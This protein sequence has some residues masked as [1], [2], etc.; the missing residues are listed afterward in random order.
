MVRG[1]PAAR[2]AGSRQW[3]RF[4][5]VDHLPAGGVCPVQ[6]L[7]G[8]AD[9]VH[10]EAHDDGQV[11]SD[12]R[13]LSE[14]P[15]APTKSNVDELARARMH[16]VII[17]TLT[18]SVSS[19]STTLITSFFEKHYALE[20]YQA[21]MHSL[22]AV[23]L[24]VF[25]T[26]LA[27][28][29]R[30]ATPHARLAAGLTLA[31][32][33]GMATIMLVTMALVSGSIS[34]TGGVDGITQGWLYAIGWW[35]HFK[36]LSLLPVAVIPA[37]RVLRSEG[38]LPAPLAWTGQVLGI[39]GPVAMIGALNSATEFLMFPVFILFMVW[40]LATGVLASTRGLTEA[41]E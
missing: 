27:A 9:A 38:V 6:Q 28:Q 16:G 14:G 17:T 8:L 10:V 20:Q 26:A 24:L 37:C 13:Y 19:T 30:R 11:T 41:A 4:G 15:T 3:R 7:R 2:P 21:L 29:V 36:C 31:A 22:A 35:E 18:R 32:G 25:F 5:L 39:L 1:G 40:T 23:A 12:S 33:A 34:L